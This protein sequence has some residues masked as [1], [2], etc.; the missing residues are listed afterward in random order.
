MNNQKNTFAGI[1][2]GITDQGSNLKWDTLIWVLP[3]E[4]GCKTYSVGQKL[5]P[6]QS[7][8]SRFKLL[9]CQ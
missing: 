2:E 9:P 6:F 1:V 8:L 4:N 7:K 5:K 3:S